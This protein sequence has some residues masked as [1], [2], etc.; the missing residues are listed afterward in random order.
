M[1]SYQVEAWLQKVLVGQ[2]IPQYEINQRTL[3]LLSQLQK[4]NERQDK[5][6][7]LI[8]QDWHQKAEEYT[9]EGCCH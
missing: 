6:A 8:I 4:R 7:E 2:E 1:Y 5:C 9:V 3:D